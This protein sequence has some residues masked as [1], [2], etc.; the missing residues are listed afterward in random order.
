MYDNF[1]IYLA[2]LQGNLRELF[3]KKKGLKKAS[4]EKMKMTYYAA[5]ADE[6]FSKSYLLNIDGWQTAVALLKRYFAL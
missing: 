1:S 3:F 4:L 2:Q 6:I 5:R